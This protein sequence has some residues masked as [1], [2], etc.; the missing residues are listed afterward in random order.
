MQEG[1][2]VRYL[3]VAHGH[4]IVVDVRRVEGV[5]G[6]LR[7]ITIH[8]DNTVTIEFDR[9]VAYAEGD[10]E[11]WGPK[12]I[13]RYDGLPKLIDSLERYLG[14][15]A[16]SWAN[17]TATPFV[18]EEVDEAFDAEAAHAHFVELI[19]GR[20][21]Q[22]PEGASYCFGDAYWDH[23]ERFGEYREELAFEDQ[24]ARWKD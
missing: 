12:Y 11:G 13:G 21:L 15:P 5:P 18:V 17:Y 19:R 7:A 10:S 23:I 8:Q 24:E 20:Q 14:C 4:S 2:I 3:A 16:A 9:A 1:E 22:L 6:V